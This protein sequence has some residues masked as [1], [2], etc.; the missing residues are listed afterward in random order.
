M[1]CAAICS[2]T[3][4]V[5]ACTVLKKP[6]IQYDLSGQGDR[7]LV[8]VHG[9]AIDASYWK[10]QVE[11]FKNEYRIVALDLAGHGRSRI[12]RDDWSPA[13]YAEDVLDILRYHNLR[14]VVLIGHSMGAN[15][16]QYVLDKGGDRV[17]GFI[18]IDSFKQL[19][20]EF[21]SLQQAQ[22]D[23]FMKSLRSEYTATATA[24]ARQAL[25][26]PTSDSAIVERVL[27]DIGSLDSLVSYRTI[28]ALLREGATERRLAETMKI[29]MYL[30]NSDATPTDERALKKY[31]RAGYKLRHLHGTGHYPMLEA[32][33]ELNTAIR[34]TLAEIK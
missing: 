21:D 30:I 6:E 33:D 4:V 17:E 8:F 5:C 25:F 11:T 9:W 10:P 3:L 20:M 26:S 1:R 27:K 29:P 2:L 34:E 22:V 14:N 18:V 16:I 7:T 23:D 19:G 31:C 28:E 24:Y 32:P 13:R 15:I 12:Q